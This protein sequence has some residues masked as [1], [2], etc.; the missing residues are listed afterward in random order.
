MAG[1]YR[2]LLKGTEFEH[3]RL[4]RA[5]Q[6]MIGVTRRTD[7]NDK[8]IALFESMK[9]AIAQEYAQRLRVGTAVPITEDYPHDSDHGTGRFANRPEKVWAPGE[10][11][12]KS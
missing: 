9:G 2:A 1:E 5:D 3:I 6:P 4:A 12:L 7:L 8:L 10:L 11:F